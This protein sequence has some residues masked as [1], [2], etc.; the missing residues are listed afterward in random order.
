MTFDRQKQLNS[1]TIPMFDVIFPHL[2]VKNKKWKTKTCFELIDSLSRNG[3]NQL[4]L[5]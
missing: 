2:K 3:R 1:F 4:M 5:I